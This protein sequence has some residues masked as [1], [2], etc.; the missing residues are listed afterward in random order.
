MKKKQGIV[1]IVGRPNTGKSTLINNILKQKVAIVSYKPQTTRNQIKA[2]YED[3][4]CKIT[5][6]DTP[7]YHAPR[8]KLDQ[9]LNSEVKRSFKGCDFVLFLLD[10]TRDINDEDIKLSKL[11]AGYNVNDYL[12]L[13]TKKDLIS[14]FDI[15]KKLNELE[16]PEQTNYILINNNSQKNIEEL[17]QKICD[18]MIDN[19]E[20]SDDANAN[21]NFIICELVREQILLNLK[22][23]VPHSTAVTIENKK[24]DENNKCLYIDA[25]I[26]VEKD[27]Q[28][29]IIIGKGGSMIKLIGTKARM[30]LLTIYDC[31]IN[32]KLFVK[33]EKQW[34]DNENVLK[35]LGYFK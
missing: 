18:K 8:N 11:I 27:S 5:F 4:K 30:Q 6:I 1:A 7:G 13:F 3:D 17:L 9:F 24:Y 20:Y 19:K 12:L 26:I 28:K 35:S 14:K 32:L 21:D 2:I 33:V 15:T 23:E 31:K 29:P 22:Q 34:R 25:A 16:L 10:L